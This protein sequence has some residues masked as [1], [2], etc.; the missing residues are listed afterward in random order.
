MIVSGAEKNLSGECNYNYVYI[1]NLLVE[2]EIFDKVQE[3]SDIVSPAIRGNAGK[4]FIALSL[5]SNCPLVKQATHRVPSAV[6]VGSPRRIA[7]DDEA[8]NR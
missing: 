5:D 2:I 6:R 1:T 7:N 8:R 4:T 3:Y